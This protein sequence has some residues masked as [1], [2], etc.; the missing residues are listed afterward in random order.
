[1]NE[2]AI[3]NVLA[4]RVANE[5]PRD[6]GIDPTIE[7]TSLTPYALIDKYDLKLQ[8]IFYTAISTAAM[9][10]CGRALRND[11]LKRRTAERNSEMIADA[12]WVRQM[13]G[14]DLP[15]NDV[16]R[17]N[18]TDSNLIEGE[19]HINCHV[20][21]ELGYYQQMPTRQVAEL[22]AEIATH[23]AK[24]IALLTP[25][26][27]ALPSSIQQ[28]IEV[29]SQGTVRGL[30][31]TQT[32]AVEE[33]AK[34]GMV[35][36][37]ALDAQRAKQAQRDA[38]QWVDMASEIIADFASLA[39]GSDGPGAFAKLPAY[40]GVR[41]FDKVS[42]SMPKRLTAFSTRV[43]LGFEPT[44]ELGDVFILQTVLQKLLADLREARIAYFRKHRDEIEAGTNS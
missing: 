5:N 42:E 2:Q 9:F 19:R 22:L 36:K 39:P 11:I 23:G 29:Y 38:Q 43:A 12:P 41:M 1:M 16:D 20:R 40:M 18:A 35:D 24:E 4:Q 27:R 14:H 6:P 28:V 30:N 10:Q 26:K 31:T 33:L 3:E 13:L 17:R 32:A 37:Q 25:D 8:E 34:R 15:T 44:F 7:S 21:N